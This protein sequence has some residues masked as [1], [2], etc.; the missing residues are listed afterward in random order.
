MT[1]KGPTHCCKWWW[2]YSFDNPLRKLFQRPDKILGPY[3]KPGMTAVDLGCG[4]GFFSIPMAKMVGDKGKVISMD[5][6]E[7]MLEITKKRAGKKGVAH[8]IETVQTRAGELILPVEA[9][10]AL[11]MWMVHEVKRQDLFM[12]NVFNVLAPGGKFLMAE[13]KIHVKKSDL[14]ESVKLAVKAG[15]VDA[16]RPKVGISIAALLEKPA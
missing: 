8:R 14:E 3:I 2:A 15:F 10:F 5:L 11:A 1:D 13:P 4:M 12:K 7:E 9:D 16:K 6:Q